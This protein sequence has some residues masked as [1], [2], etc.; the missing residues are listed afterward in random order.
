MDTENDDA[1]NNK[2]IIFPAFQIGFSELLH[3]IR[4]M[5][6]FDLHNNILLIC[7]PEHAAMLQPSPIYMITDHFKS[8]SALI[9]KLVT[10][11][12]R[13]NH[14]FTGLIAID[15]EEQFR[16]SF[17][18]ALHFGVSFFKEDTCRLAS[19]KY[20]MKTAFLENGVPTGRGILISDTRNP[21]IADIGF[22]NVLKII[23]GTQSHGV[24]LNKNMEDLERNFT[25][26][27]ASAG[28]ISKNHRPPRQPQTMGDRKPVFNVRK[29]FLLEEYIGGEEYSCDFIKQGTEVRVVRVVKKIQ[30]VA[31]GYF[32]GY[33]LLN[34]EGMNRGGIDLSY[35]REVCS[36]IARSFSMDWGGGMVDF[37]VDAGRLMVLES[38][39]RPGFSAFNHLMYRV[40]GYTS[41]ALMAKQMM[42]NALDVRIPEA[43]G[44]V[45]YLYGYGDGKNGEFNV[46]ALDA[47]RQEYNILDIWLYGNE[48]DIIPDYSM[49][50]TMTFKGYV[51][52]SPPE[53]EDLEGLSDLFN[54]K[55]NA[56]VD[57]AYN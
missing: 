9:R 3:F 13:F 29:H 37:K 35:L 10:W 28:R 32:K 17:K 34:E 26:L 31:M 36:R 43:N 19:N 21:Q 18:I 4:S 50:R 54:R 25:N 57:A 48:D 38:S 53:E 45:L 1:P 30:G 47:Y 5:Q 2:I 44:A 16:L 11:R 24:F 27:A 49:N 56:A 6:N 20:L 23:S 40:Y 41:L 55:V 46:S 33:K 7:T 39:I 14:T 51:L 52:L 15:E 42:G 8:P 22:P 12:K